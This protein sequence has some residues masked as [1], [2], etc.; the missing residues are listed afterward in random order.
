MIAGKIGW[1]R[2]SGQLTKSKPGPVETNPSTLGESE[3][4]P[5]YLSSSPAEQVLRR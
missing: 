3:S 4:G 2:I 1:P 5:K